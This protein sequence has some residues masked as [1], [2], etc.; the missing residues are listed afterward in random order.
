M[1]QQHSCF[2]GLLLAVGACAGLYALR[3]SSAHADEWGCE[4]L[5]CMSNPAGP[6][7]VAQ[8]VPPIE[9]YHHVLKHGGARPTCSESGWSGAIGYEAHECPVGYVL[10]TKQGYDNCE[11]P[12]GNVGVLF[13]AQ[14]FYIEI[15]NSNGLPGTQRI[16][17]PFQ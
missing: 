12:A 3:P 8:C 15:P 4:V 14:P 1:R 7:A 17:L 16:W 2:K 9:R 13:R 11:S 6:E 5:L 10:T